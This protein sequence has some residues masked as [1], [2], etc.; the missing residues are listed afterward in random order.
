MEI[1]VYECNKCELVFGEAGVC[2]KCLGKLT[3]AVYAPV[4]PTHRISLASG[5]RKIG[6][7]QPPVVAESEK[8]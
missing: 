5:I 7:R 6:L 2:S 4:A 8:R 1:T 3:P